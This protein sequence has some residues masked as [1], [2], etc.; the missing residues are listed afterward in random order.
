MNNCD[1]ECEKS[2]KENRPILICI[3]CD[4]DNQSFVCLLVMK[5]FTLYMTLI[6]P[7]ANPCITLAIVWDNNLP[8]NSC[9]QYLVITFCRNKIGG[10]IQAKPGV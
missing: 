2:P 3:L 6:Q 1:S 10:S 8:H 9:P 4:Q 5:I 7:K